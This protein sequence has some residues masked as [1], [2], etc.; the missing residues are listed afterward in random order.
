MEFKVLYTSGDDVYIVQKDK[1]FYLVNLD[2]DTPPIKKD[3]VESFVKF[4]YFTAVDKLDAATLKRIETRLNS[5][6]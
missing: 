1:A 4:G 6:S 2:V 5:S 3:L